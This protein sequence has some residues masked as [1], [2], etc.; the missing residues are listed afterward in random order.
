MPTTKELS[1]K[2]ANL[3][4]MSE[5]IRLK[6]EGKKENMTSTEVNEW[7]NILK[8]ADETRDQLNAALKAEELSKWSNEVA[9]RL[10]LPGAS[11]KDIGMGGN[12]GGTG[13]PDA[14]KKAWNKFLRGGI[15]KMSEPE[16]KAIGEATSIKAYQADDPAGGGFLVGPQTFVAEIL[17]YMKNAVWLRKMATIYTLNRSESLGVPTLSTDPSDSDWTAELLVGGTES[18]MSIG[19]RELRPSPIAKNIQLS[20]KLIRNSALNVE[21][22]VQDRLGYK[23]AVTME[24]AYQLGTGANQ[25]LGVYVADSNGISTARD[26]TAAS[27]TAIAGDD[28]IKTF[29]N[30]KVQYRTDSQW[31]LHRTVVQAVRILKDSQNSYLWQPG[32]NSYVAQGTALIGR[33]PDT[34]MGC[35]IMESEYSPNTFTTGLYTMLLG[36]FKYYWIC[37]ALDMQLQV[38]NELYAATN[39]TG[40]ILRMETDGAPVLEEAF[41]RLKLA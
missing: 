7:T 32:L 37:D 39:Q 36:N 19:R 6:Y 35:P 4:T 26:I 41:S 17:T 29:Y 28:V 5:A 3:H 9:N 16:L 24:K 30:L 21:A 10:P 40:Y 34:L 20:N 38:L 25:P 13:M 2:I 33:Q 22:I 23:M 8:E 18:T 31:L 15:N 14:A 27:S 12:G 1:D 11:G